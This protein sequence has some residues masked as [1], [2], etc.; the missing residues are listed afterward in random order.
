MGDSLKEKGSTPSTNG[1]T[2][3]L[4]RE[5]IRFYEG[6]R[7]ETYICPA[8]IPTCCTGHT[9]PEVKMGQTYTPTQCDALLA[10]D[11]ERFEKCIN[12][13]IDPPLTQTQFDSLISW[14]FNVGAGAVQESTLRRRLNAG[15]DVNT[16]IS[17]E[18]PRWCNGPNGPLEGLVKRR[19]AEVKLAVEGVFP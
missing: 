9:G 4:G 16:V 7:L 14:S 18:L 10:K 13:L 2:G 8:G 15:E 11:L 6:T 17:S 19:A 3:T 5:L 1:K 12:D